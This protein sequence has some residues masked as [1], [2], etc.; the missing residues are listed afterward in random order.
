MSEVRPYVSLVAVGHNGDYG[1]NFVERMQ[2]FLDVLFELAA[3]R[4]ADLELILV[5]WN[6]PAGKPS[7]A[8]VLRWP[9][10][11]PFPVRFVEVPAE[12]H[13]RL[14]NADTIPV[15]EFIA[16]NVGIRRAR[17][18]FVLATNPDNVFEPAIIDV[19]ARR[20]LESDSFYRVDRLDVRAPLPEG[21]VRERLAFCRRHIWRVNELGRSVVF[22]RPPGWWASRPGQLRRTLL[23]RTEERAAE[24]APE[25]RVHTNASGDFL[26]MHRERWRELRGF[27][28]LTT[29][30]H[31]DGYMCV[32]AA[33]AG[34]KQRILD[35][36]CRI[37][38]QEHA[39]AIDWSNLEATTWPLT[40]YGMFYRDAREMLTSGRPKIFNDPDWGLA[41]VEL[42]ET[43]P[44]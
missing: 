18:E 34:L 35:G 12:V 9:E 8:S 36:W 16:K 27:P 15:F 31:I 7:L 19:F 10:P 14:P 1:G 23:A 28:E 2:N 4:R 11:L 40:D 25:S 29:G 39:R 3:R 41:D 6:P 43:A 22:D 42:V 44:A 21:T 33:A 37:Y 30:A 38:H 17:G 32:M 26:L 5:E 24:D 13:E 20:K